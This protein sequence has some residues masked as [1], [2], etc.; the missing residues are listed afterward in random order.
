MVSQ[1]INGD[2]DFTTEAASDLCEYLGLSEREAEHFLLLVDL[3]RAGSHGLKL[4]ITKR[5]ER[6]REQAKQLSERMQ[7]DRDLSDAE[8]AV[9]YSH[10]IYTAITHLVAVQ[11]DIGS[12]EVAVRLHVPV[13][14]VSRAIAFLLDSGILAHR[15]SGYA[16]GLKMSHI[17]A[18]SPLVVKH[19]HNWRLQAFNRMS[20]AKDSDLFYTAP[21]SLSREV[22]ERIRADLPTYIQKLIGWVGPSES[23]VV[24]CLN[25]DWFAW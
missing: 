3:A 7:K 23:E 2:K 24:R 5:I 14:F 8:S 9:Y 4:R 25:V 13:H 15:G 6:S 19:H 12:E 22:A 10:W 11:S 16:I 1:V 17:G 18:D 21:M 20:Y